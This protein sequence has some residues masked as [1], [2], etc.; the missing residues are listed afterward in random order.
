MK[1]F[2]TKI[3]EY[4]II[5]YHEIKAEA[6]AKADMKEQEAKDKR[7]EA[8]YRRTTLIC[9]CCKEVYKKEEYFKAFIKKDEIQTVLGRINFMKCKKCKELI[10]VVVDVDS[11]ISPNIVVN[12]Y[13]VF[14]KE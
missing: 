9:P 5:R 6:K 1:K 12:G 11:L 10:C 13:S 7:D 2:L 4:P 14:D 3:L 8:E